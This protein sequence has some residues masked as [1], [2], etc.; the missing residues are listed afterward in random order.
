[1]RLWVKSSKTTCTVPG[2]MR[3]GYGNSDLCQMHYKRAQM[4]GTAGSAEPVYV[5]NGP[6]ADRFW[7]KADK[8]GPLPP[9]RPELGPCWLWTR[10]TFP[11]GYGLFQYA[12]RETR[13]AH[14]VAYEL[15]I[16]PIPEGLTIDHVCHN[17]NPDCA[18]GKTCSHRRCVN[19]A[20]MEAVTKGVN[21]SR[22]MAAHIVA[23]RLD[24][25]AKGHDLTD[26]A[27]IKTPRLTGPQRRECR[28]C[29]R[30][31]RMERYERLGR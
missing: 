23:S 26:P 1:M 24:V 3:S 27:N 7:S 16:G 29:A 12:T 31:A 30:L 20:H 18:G 6:L 9:H 19:P 2:C 15:A 10:A 17:D 11:D 28:L 22:G 8:G 14:R 25:C 21:T 4:T 5:R 13:G